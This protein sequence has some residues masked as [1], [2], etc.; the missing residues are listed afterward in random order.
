ME[1]SGQLHAPAALP[2][3]ERAPGIHWIGGWMGS[4]AGLGDVEK[5]KFFMLPGLE[6][7]PLHRQ[8]HSQS[9]Y[10]LRYHGSY[11]LKGFVLLFFLYIYIYIYMY[12]IFRFVVNFH[13]QMW[14][15]KDFSWSFVSLCLLAS[16][17]L[18]PWC[19]LFCN[20]CTPKSPSSMNNPVRWTICCTVYTKSV[21]PFQWYSL[22]DWEEQ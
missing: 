14:F 10:R 2:S 12:K 21:G 15:K 7:H 11:H 20:T 18:L 4:K 17:S 13:A 8:A 1:V 5:W 6:L 22:G 3:E 19:Q 16:C 9:L